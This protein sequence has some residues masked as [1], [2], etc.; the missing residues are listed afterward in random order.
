MGLALAAC[1]SG[2]ETA[3][4]TNFTASLAGD[5]EIPN[6][7]TAATGS[8]TCTLGS[9]TVSCTVDY[10]GLSG[11]PTAS[12]IHLAN[13]N[14]TGSIRVNL[15]GAGTAPAC[16]ATATGQIVSGPQAPTGATFEAV[17]AAMRNYGAY[18]N[19]HTAANAGGEIRGQIFGVY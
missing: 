10:A 2:D 8:A 15:C 16:P 3:A 4:A 17:A 7:V 13:A 18:V 12:H 19:V 9:G 5:H 14:T 11:A 6:V 1:S